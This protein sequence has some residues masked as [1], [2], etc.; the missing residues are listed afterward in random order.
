MPAT[1]SGIRG[2]RWL[3]TRP[4][5]GAKITV[6]AASGSVS[7]PACSAEYPRTSCRYSVLRNRKPPSA[8]NALTAITV[9]PEN[10]ALRKNLRSSSGS[11][12]RG[13]YVSS[14]PRA[15][16]DRQKQPMISGERQPCPG[17]S[18][19]PK[20]SEARVTITSTWPTGST[21]RGCGALDSGTNSAVSTIAATPTGM[22]TQKIPRQ[23]TD[24]ISRPPTT[25]PRARLT[26][27][28]PPQTPIARARSARSV[29]VFTMID[30]ATGLSIDPPTACSI[31]NATSQPR[32]GARL[33]SSEPTVKVASPAW[34]VL[35]RP[36]RSAVEPDRTRRLA[37]TSVYASTTHCSPDTGA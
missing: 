31:R 15:T 20:I 7:S 26:P 36:S 13:S 8:A 29:N 12:R 28:A 35:R 14:A 32:L 18:M 9:A 34:N 19:I 2:P 22:F 17:P 4:D 37:S 10:G 30:I 21:R 27:T 3:M 11:R 33:H 5:S 23:P 25:G 24:A 16:A 1:M 6:T